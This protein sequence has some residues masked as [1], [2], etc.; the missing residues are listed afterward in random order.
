MLNIKAP[1]KYINEENSILLAGKYISN[2]TDKA[3]VIGGKKAL[4]KAGPILFSSLDEAGISYQTELFSGYC[5]KQ[6]IEKFTEL[7]KQT[8]AGVVIGVGGGK[9]LDTVKAVAERAELPV[10][11]IPTIAATC[12]AWSALS[13][14]YNEHGAVTEF[15]T[16]DKSPNLILVD[17]KIIV[18]APVRYLQAGIADT[19]VKWYE[20][21]P[22]HKN[23]R[24]E[25]S[26]Q[27]SLNTAKQALT[28]LNE[29]SLQAI[30]DNNERRVTRPLKEVINAIIAL[31][32]LV[33]SVVGEK[34]KMAI[35][36]S[37][38]N[39]MTYLS[40]THGS[41]HGE[42]VI[43]GLIAQFIL[44]GK[45]KSEINQLVSQLNEYNLPVSL[46]QL[47]IEN[48]LGKKINEIA[49]GIKINPEDVANLS[50]DVTIPLIEDAI[51]SANEIGE[52]SLKVTNI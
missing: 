1:E 49:S 16:L 29:N 33:G 7:T 13:V 48:N 26:L 34:H 12:A 21:V 20:F 39:S 42:K 27:I 35:A 40:E 46:K 30:N 31:A 23:D 10:V 5:T 18:E 28:I 3:I 41:L 43:F 38:H 44:E 51:K 4:E 47:G 24:Y 45:S 17:P 6:A 11:T 37:I 9:V 50:F 32:G 15:I 52:K 25:F 14:V 19:I 8:N 2:I 36:H 22:Y